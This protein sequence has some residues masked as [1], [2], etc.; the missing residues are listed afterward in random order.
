MGIFGVRCRCGRWKT[1]GTVC[2]H[3][4]TPPA[5]GHEK[6]CVDC[7]DQQTSWGQAAR[8]IDARP[9]PTADMIA[10][11]RPAGRCERCGARTYTTTA[12]AWCPTAFCDP[13]PD[14]C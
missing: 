7:K 4:D 5:D 2:I 1:G 11:N 3:C 9:A 8:Q 14:G 13:N 6:V 10:D 12:G